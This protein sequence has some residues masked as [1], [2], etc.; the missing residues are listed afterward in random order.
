MGVGSGVV[1]G[2]AKVLYDLSLMLILGVGYTVALTLT[3]FVDEGL[4]CIAWDS[5]GVT[6][7]PVTVPLVLSMGVGLCGRIGSVDGFGILTCAS[8][9]PIISCLVASLV[10]EKLF[11]H[12]ARKVLQSPRIGYSVSLEEEMSILA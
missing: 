6:T 7:G 11:P 10:R 9:C 5:A 8:V 3:I 4:C 1:L 2:L 12:A